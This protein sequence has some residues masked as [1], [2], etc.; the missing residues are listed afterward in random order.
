MIA[1]DDGLNRPSPGCDEEEQG[2]RWVVPHR[3]AWKRSLPGSEEALSPSTPGLWIVEGLDF[4]GVNR[5]HVSPRQVSP[6]CS[7]ERDA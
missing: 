2:R 3:R 1:A 4:N 7:F 6:A 5:I